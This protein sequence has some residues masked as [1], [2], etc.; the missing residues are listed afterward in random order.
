MEYPGGLLEKLAEALRRRLTIIGDKKMR[1]SNSEEHLAMLGEIS[2]EIEQIAHS[3]P[4]ESHPRLLHFLERASYS[5][6]LA[7]L[8]SSKQ[9][10][11][12]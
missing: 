10:S 3:L 12:H 9:T 6:A 8:E 11:S 7:F 5:K 2:K 1:E 4:P